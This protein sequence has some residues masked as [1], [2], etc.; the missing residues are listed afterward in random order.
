MK[1][2]HYMI[3][4]ALLAL[5]AAAPAVAATPCDGIWQKKLADG[6]ALLRQMPAKQRPDKPKVYDVMQS[7]GFSIVWAEFTDA[8][9]GGYIFNKTRLVEVWGG[10]A[11]TDTAADLAGW[12]LKQDKAMP[13][14]LANC[15]G[16]YV[17]GGREKSP[18]ARKNPFSQ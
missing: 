2:F 16:W 15:F 14:P 4:G 17:A 1:N 18:P 7:G 6:S 9:P 10:V 3:A 12:A 11:G 8:E 13:R 5:A